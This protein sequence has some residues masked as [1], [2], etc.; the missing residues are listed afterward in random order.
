MRFLRI[1]PV[2]SV[3]YN[4]TQLSGRGFPYIF[5]IKLCLSQ[6]S[7][8][9]YS[10]MEAGLCNLKICKFENLVVDN[11]NFQKFEH[12]KNEVKNNTCLVFEIL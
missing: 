9:L 12:V 8:F 6:L 1:H 4:M 7:A 3:V 2:Q 11:L 5:H 10:K